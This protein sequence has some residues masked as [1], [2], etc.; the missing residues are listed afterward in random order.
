MTV[1]HES[2]DQTTLAR[3]ARAALLAEIEHSRAARKSVFVIPAEDQVIRLLAAAWPVLAAEE[4]EAGTPC[5]CWCS[6][7]AICQRDDDGTPG[8]CDSCRME[9]HQERALGASGG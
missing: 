4:C 3:A 8:W 5:N 1:V 2:P 6:C 9:I 7:P